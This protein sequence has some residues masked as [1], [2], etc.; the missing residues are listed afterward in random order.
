MQKRSP[1]YKRLI[2]TGMMC[3][4]LAGC[5]TLA[6]IK[7]AAPDTGIRF[8]HPQHEA[9]D[10][11][12]CHEI[13]GPTAAMPGHDNCSTCHEIDMD[14]PSDEACGFCHT[15]KDLSITRTKRLTDEIIFTHEE[16]V[17]KEIACATCH[18]DPDKSPLPKGP[19]MPF[20][21]DCH[22][23]TSAS[24]TCDTCHKEIRKDTIPTKRAGV[25]IAH[26]APQIWENTHGQEYRFDPAYCGYCHD[27]DTFC[28]DCHQ[29][30]PPRDHTI[31]WRRKPHGLQ[32]SWDRNRCTVC[33]DEDSCRKCHENTQP[34]SHRGGWDR[35]RNKHCVNCHLPA[36]DTSCTV[37]HEEIDHRLAAK[38]SPHALGLYPPTCGLCHPGGNP[39][40]APHPMNSTTT[41]RF[42]H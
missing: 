42:C 35:P 34:E 16:H 11:A 10:C 17:E 5:A 2:V 21:M 26:D 37:C 23:K 25:R 31:S 40:R 14:N 1:Q 18:P 36:Q 8:S 20:C 9:M 29:K 4:I 27:N 41:C 13:S 3:L 15:N 7:L 32:A 33:H 6:G 22:E 38:P 12:D 19:L 24:N 28:Q 30:T 39:F